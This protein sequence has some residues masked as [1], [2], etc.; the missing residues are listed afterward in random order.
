MTVEE[1]IKKL[2]NYPKGMEVKR[3]DSEWDV[4]EVDDIYTQNSNSNNSLYSDV[5]VIN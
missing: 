2:H 5:L 3:F 1:L 4:V